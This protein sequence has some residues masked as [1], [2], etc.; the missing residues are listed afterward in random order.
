MLDELRGNVFQRWANE[1]S[2]WIGQCRE[3]RA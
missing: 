3:G 2:V 1:A